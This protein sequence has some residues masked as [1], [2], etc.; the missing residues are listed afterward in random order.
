MDDMILNIVVMVLM[1]FV[2]YRQDK[3]IE[4]LLEEIDKLKEKKNE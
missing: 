4:K 2:W 3:M 1:T